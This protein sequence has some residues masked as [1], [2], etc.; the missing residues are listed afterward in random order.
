MQDFRFYSWGMMIIVRCSKT[1]QFGQRK[2]L[3][4]IARVANRDIC[5][6]HWVSRHFNEVPVGPN[7]L[8][9]QVPASGG[10]YKPLEYVTLNS[11]IKH[12]ADC[13][14]LDPSKFLSHSLRRGRCTFLAMEGASLEEIKSR[15]D[16]SSDTVFAYITTPLSE[17]ILADMCVAVAL[18]ATVS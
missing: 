11:T 13:A 2:L 18:S 5:A 17:R 10:G 9:F 16:W 15:G 3:I 6:I 4:P 14:G 12:F 7:E 8:A 1:I